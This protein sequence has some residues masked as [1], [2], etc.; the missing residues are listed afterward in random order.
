MIPKNKQGLT[1]VE[2]IVVVAVLIILGAAAY[3]WAD[4]VTFIGQ[5]KDRTRKQDITSLANAFVEYANDHDG[6][7][8][9]L[10]AVT[11][12]KKVLCTTQAAVQQLCGVEL[13][14]CL[15]I[16]DDEFF[17]KY[18]TKMPIDPE[19]SS[20]SYYDTGYYVK[21]DANNNLT[22]GSCDYDIDDV[23]YKPKL[24]ATCDAYAGGYCWYTTASA[25]QNCDTVCA[26]QDK[27]CVENVTYSY[28]SLC[29]LNNAI[30][31]AY[32][33]ASG[34]SLAAAGEPPS[35]L[36]NNTCFYQEVVFAC[37]QAPASGMAVCPCQ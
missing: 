7:L 9:I 16:D 27:I 15:E 35:W 10:G 8:P 30:N 33:C 21:L 23:Y 2:L 13:Q 1:L 20:S 26:A 32:T 24:Q 6:A 36:E 31:G 11:S 25:S 37:D 19:K 12:D 18:L 28:D 5:A 29:L 3:L 14:Y 4:P 34:C 17:S 22:F